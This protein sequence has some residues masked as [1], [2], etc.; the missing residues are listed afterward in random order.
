VQ[1]QKVAEAGR[2]DVKQLSALSASAA[3]N[4]SCPR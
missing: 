1:V 3:L 2:A 4:M